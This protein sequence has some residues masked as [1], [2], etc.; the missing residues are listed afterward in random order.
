MNHK[1]ARK[2]CHMIVETYCPGY[3]LLMDRLSRDSYAS[4]WGLG[5]NR[6]EIMFAKNAKE[7]DPVYMAKYELTKNS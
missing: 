6:V 1:R 5:E 3:Y 2:I 7:G 4:L